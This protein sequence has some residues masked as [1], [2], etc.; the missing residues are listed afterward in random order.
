MRIKQLN[1]EGNSKLMVNQVKTHCEARNPRL[2]RYRDVVWDEIE[3]FNA[4]NITYVTRCGFEFEFNEDYVQ[5][6]FE[7]SNEVRMRFSFRFDYISTKE[8]EALLLGLQCA[9][10]MRI[11]QLNEEGNS[12]LMVNQVKTHCEAR[13][14][15]LRRYRDAVWD[16][17]ECFN[18]FNIT[19]VTRCGFEFEFNEDYVQFGFEF[20]NEVRMRFSFRFDYISTKEYEALLLGLQCARKMRIKQLNEEGNSK[21]MVNQVKTHC[22]AR[23]PRLRRYR[24][25]VWDEIE[26]FN[27]FNIT[28]VTRCG[29][30][31][32]FNE[33]YVHSGSNFPM[34]FG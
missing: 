16:E 20:S 26:C 18:A 10:K 31:F 24:D 13:N 15:R 19:Y 5:F 9:R 30:E 28:Y 33:D 22:E 12:K 1:K 7:V 2:R 8:Y 32:E 11:K 27:A 14:P 25:A 4:F 3:C 23:N 17:I 34:R 6:R 21:L 29:F